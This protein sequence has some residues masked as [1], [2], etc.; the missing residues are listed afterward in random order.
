MSQDLRST[1]LGLGIAF[2]VIFAGLTLYA[3][4]DLTTGLRTYGDL[5]GLFFYVVSFGVIVMIG[6]G[7][8]GAIKNPPPDE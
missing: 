6:L 7:L 5:F 1:L 3:A 8:W 4:V 2:C